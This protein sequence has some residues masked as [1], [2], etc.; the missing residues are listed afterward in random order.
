MNSPTPS[1]S[2]HNKHNYDHIYEILIVIFIIILCYMPFYFYR[3]CHFNYRRFLNYFVTFKNKFKIHPIQL[4]Q[5]TREMSHLFDFR[6][7]NR[8]SPFSI[9]V[10]RQVSNQELIVTIEIPLAVIA[11][12]PVQPQFIANATLM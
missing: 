12:T 11:T 8:I 6:R 1:P 5:E 7:T 10:T 4:T 9:Q 3:F 2:I